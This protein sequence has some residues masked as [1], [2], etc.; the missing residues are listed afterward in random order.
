MSVGVLFALC[1]LDGENGG[2]FSSDF[3]VFRGLRFVLLRFRKPLLYPA[4]LP[5]RID[6][7]RIAR[8]MPLWLGRAGRV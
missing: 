4:E 3:N 6:A 5:G 7:E 1:A 8:M 2:E